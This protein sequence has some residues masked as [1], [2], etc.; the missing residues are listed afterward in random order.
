[1]AWACGVPW[2]INPGYQKKFVFVNMERRLDSRDAL[3]KRH[4]V[5]ESN[6]RSFRSF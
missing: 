2:T 6:V 1:M 3:G 5:D 4:Q